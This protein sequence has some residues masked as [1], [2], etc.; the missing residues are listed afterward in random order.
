L[1]GKL[2][3]TELVH[4]AERAMMDAESVEADTEVLSFIIGRLGLADVGEFGL[5]WHDCEEFLRR[6]GYCG[7]GRCRTRKDQPITP[8]GTRFSGPEPRRTSTP[9]AWPSYSVRLSSCPPGKTFGLCASWSF[10]A[11]KIVYTTPREDI[12][13]N[14]VWPAAMAEADFETSP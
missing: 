5:R 2:S 12:I 1:H 7:T 10:A 3:Q 14:R 4:W 13:V 8:S 11:G 6:L 9:A